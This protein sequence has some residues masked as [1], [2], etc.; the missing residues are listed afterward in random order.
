[1]SGTDKTYTY[2]IKLPKEAP[3]TPPFL[4]N[5]YTSLE[6]QKITTKSSTLSSYKYGRDFEFEKRFKLGRTERAKLVLRAEWLVS[7]RSY[8]LDLI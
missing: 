2:F 7:A 8:N 4:Y 1:M 3:T 5:W 6:G